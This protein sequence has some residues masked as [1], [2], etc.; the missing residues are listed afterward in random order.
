[1]STVIRLNER[2]AIELDPLTIDRKGVLLTLVGRAQGDKLTC[3][4]IPPEK[5]ASLVN[6]LQLA[7]LEVAPR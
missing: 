6:A 3:V 4:V 2:S 5:V 1:M 7:A